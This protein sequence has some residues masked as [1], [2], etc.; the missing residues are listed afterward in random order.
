MLQ[1]I[2]ISVQFCNHARYLN[3]LGKWDDKTTDM[4]VIYIKYFELLALIDFPWE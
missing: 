4:K 2:N 3:K 1:H